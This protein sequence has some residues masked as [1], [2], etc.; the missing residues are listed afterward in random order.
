VTKLGTSVTT[1]PAA[2]PLDA[3]SERFRNQSRQALARAT[4]ERDPPYW[5]SAIRAAENSSK[6]ESTSVFML[7]VRI[8]TAE[9]TVQLQELLVI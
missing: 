5:R 2:R 4:P 8:E 1:S 7:S 6:R 9:D 3:L